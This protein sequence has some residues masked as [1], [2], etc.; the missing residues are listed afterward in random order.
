[1]SRECFFCAD[2]GTSS[3]KAALIDADGHE[4]A[5]VRQ[6]YPATGRAISAGDWETALYRAV[7]TIRQSAGDAGV[8]ALCIS[9]NG[10]TLVPVTSAGEPLPLLHWYN[11]GQAQVAGMQSLFLSH[12]DWFLH[13]KPALYAM[14]RYLFSAQEWL[15][16]R[17]GAEPVTALPTFAY[18]P[19]YWD[20]DQCRILEVDRKKFPE[21]VAMGSVIG[22][23]MPGLFPEPV[24]IVAGGPDFIMALIGTGTVKPGMVCDRAGMSE[25]INLC[26]ADPVY[27]ETKGKGDP[28]R[29]LPHPIAGLWNLSGLIPE[30]GSRFEDYRLRRRQQDRDYHELLVEIVHGQTA[31]AQHGMT[32]LEKLA[33][34]VRQTLETFNRY[35]YP[36]T[37]MRLSG[38]QCKSPVWNKLKAT[39]TGCTL[40]V[41]E[42]YDGELAGNA[43]LAATAT[44]LYPDWLTAIDAMIRVS[45]VWSH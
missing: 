21:F 13:H 19:Y 27:K 4:I 37:E 3:L 36:V 40:L 34:D 38:G 45:E 11:N 28:L 16:W 42:I 41:P 25:G 20:E 9:G 44:G 8:T 31:L 32:V 18:Q 17:L 24:P 6:S 14:T 7:E 12:V 29:T 35:G 23:T 39:L 22:T 2:I 1:M 15:A 30:S 43:I 10:P 5:F 26:T 33:S